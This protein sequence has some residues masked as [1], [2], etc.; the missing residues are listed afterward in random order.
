MRF[1]H[2]SDW[3]I[4]RNVR[5][6]SRAEEQHAVLEE[7]AA[8]VAAEKIDAVLIAGDVFDHTAP[9]ADDEQIA[10]EA[11]L[12]ITRA[13]AHVVLI[14]GNHDHP[15]RLDALTPFLELANIRAGAKLR[16]AAAGGCV[17]LHTGAGETACIALMPW[18]RRSNIIKADDLMA[19]ELAK[20]QSVYSASWKAALRNLSATFSARTVNIALAHV[21]FT[22]A[23]IGG[24]ER[25]SE[26]AEDYWVPKQELELN[27]AQYLALGH[28]HKQQSL[29]LTVPAWYC[30]SPLQLDFGEEEDRKGVLVLE[31]SAGLPV[32]D[33]RAVP[34]S[35]GRRMLTIG[36]PGKHYRDHPSP[37]SLEHLRRLAASG[38]LGDA[39]LR[40]FV[41]EPARPGLADEVRE[42]LPN[43]VEVK[44]EQAAGAVSVSTREGM[45]P[46]ELLSMYL[47]Q[48]KQRDEDV[49]N[50][51]DELVEEELASTPP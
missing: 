33:V 14:S 3:H 42:L 1:L 9:S 21:V 34:L 10:Y 23:M 8:I 13:G 49:L 43:A 38:V 36:G 39:Y 2:T 15:D 26:T 30:G 5:G 44:V 37:G 50:L 31:A 22:G 47:D 7:I 18:L 29:G 20:H 45:Q 24:G 40:V 51:F 11:L 12:D 28:I 35:A 25:A 6:R 19:A 41:N 4:G 27:G 46:G 17:E 32:S 48:G 16:E